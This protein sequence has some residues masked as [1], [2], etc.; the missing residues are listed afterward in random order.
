M[1]FDPWTYFPYGNASGQFGTLYDQIVATVALVAGLGS[2]SDHTIA[3]T[4]LVAPAVFGAAAAVPTYVIGRRMGG[5]ISGIFSVLILAFASGAFLRRSFAGFSDHH[6]AEALFQAIAVLGVMVAITVAQ[7]EKPIYEQFTERDYDGLQ[8]TVLWAAL[9]GLGM[10]LYMWVW[11]FGVLVYGIVGTFLLLQMVLEVLR[12]T[13]PEHTAIAGTLAMAVSGITVASS[14]TTVGITASEFS[15][16]Q[17]LLAVTVAAGCVFLAWLAR[18]WDQ[19]DLD[20]SLYAA[21]VGG[22][23]VAIAGLSAVLTPDLYGYFA[24]QITR[25]FGLGFTT[26]ETAG[27]VGEITPLVRWGREGL[28]AGIDQLFNAYGF[29]LFVAFLGLVVIVGRQILSRDQSAEQLLVAVWA[30]FA[31]AMTFTQARFQYYLLVPMAA[32]TGF[33][34]HEAIQLLD[35]EPDLRNIET[36]QVLAVGALLLVLLVPIAPTPANLDAEARFGPGN[37]VQAW[38]D[39]LNWVQENTPAE[40]NFNES[41]NELDYYGTYERSGDF[42]YPAGTYG[43]ISWWDYGHWITGMGERIPNA[44]PFQ[45]GAT[46]AANFLLAPN[47][48]QANTVLARMS[49]D[50]VATRYVMID[51]QMVDTY[52]N[53]RGKFFAPTQFYDDAEVSTSD[54][55]QRVFYNTERAQA[56][57]VQSQAYYES[58]MVR[59]Y[60]HHGSAVEPQPFV[61]DWK[62]EQVQDRF[63]LPTVPPE[64]GNVVKTFRSM[65]QARAY[66]ENDTDGTSQVGGF[67]GNPA[68]RVPAMEQYRL[69]GASEQRATQSRN[70][71]RGVLA[72]AQGLLGQSELSVVQTPSQ[73]GTDISTP[74]STQSGIAV[75]C[76]SANGESFLQPTEPRWTKTFERVPGA[77]IEGTAPA[78]STV[79]ASVEMRMPNSNETFVYHQDRDTGTDG[80]F[81][82]TVPYSTTGYDEWGPANG[83]TNVS[84][85]AN[86]SYQFQAYREAGNQLV[87]LGRASGNVTEA[88]VIG[89]SDDVTSVEL[90]RPGA[91]TGNES[92]ATG[93]S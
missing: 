9:A 66:V 41:G 85:R 29:A 35:L 71:N 22:I 38:G 30:I 6:V 26:S 59:L 70:Y 60:Q 74:I 69:V 89:E 75:L 44:N 86:T 25:I 2:P 20:G 11:P 17:P 49:E 77:T 50:D 37:G 4:L 33:A 45:Q 81:T 21:T 61:V 73:C 51:H 83:H 52:S 64:Q 82:M 76:L 79:R 90:T 57:R 63:V 10:T 5:R 42:D 15:L 84:V 14:F 68:E 88:Q 48:S 40:G 92:D 34:V 3:L 58:T 80:E 13:S 56:F 7:R 53:N 36:Y 54:Y 93:G 27:T 31:L 67:G 39:N 43:I 8:S 87:P 78:N 19:R 72:S 47:E 65:A 91:T 1:P 24:N 16:L 32:L 18:E 46:E 62:T 12:G 55:T 28:G 23:L